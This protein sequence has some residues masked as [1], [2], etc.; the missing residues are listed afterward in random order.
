MLP[1][2]NNNTNDSFTPAAPQKPI[3]LLVIELIHH[4]DIVRRLAELFCE[5]THVKIS[6]LVSANV[7]KQADLGADIFSHL[8]IRIKNTNDCIKQFLYKN[9]DFINSADI[10][11]FNTIEKYFR[12]YAKFEF[13][14]PLIIRIHNVNADLAPW[15]HLDFSKGKFL[16]TLSYSI[17]RAVLQRRFYFKKKLIEKADKLIF[18]NELITQH[19]IE[20]G[21]LT[22]E[23]VLAPI[24]PFCYLK[25]TNISAAPESTTVRIAITGT[26]DTNRKDYEIVYRAFEKIVGHFKKCVHL[27]FLGRPKG[28]SGIALVKKFETLQSEYFNFSYNT[29]FVPAEEYDRQFQD[30]DFIIAPINVNTNY[31]SFTE[32]YGRSKLSGVENDII[33]HQKP[34]IITQDYPTGNDLG[35]V[36]ASYGS[37]SELV[38]LLER[39]ITLHEFEHYQNRFTEL[40]TYQI[41]HILQ[42]C[43]NHF[44]QLIGDYHR[45]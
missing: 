22:N 5:G 15:R 14:K 30:I 7:Y 33:S 28:E 34:A 9:Q 40:Y 24:L 1:Q 10:I 13:R 21:K 8:N 17:R 18:A 16:K 45:Q 32:V 42:Q 26:I 23:K 29:D 19:A 38:E 4:A 37:E 25:A 2:S 35:K 27:K 12:D 43:T 39:W 44:E 20:T 31:R 6:F 41:T 36:C 3:K 11:Y